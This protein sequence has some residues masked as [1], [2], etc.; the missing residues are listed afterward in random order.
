[1]VKT[2]VSEEIVRRDLD[3]MP[4]R[5]RSRLGILYVPVLRLSIIELEITRSCL[6]ERYYDALKVRPSLDW[7]DQSSFKGCPATRFR[8]P[9]V[10]SF[11]PCASQEYK[12][13]HI[14]NPPDMKHMRLID[15]VITTFRDNLEEVRRITT[16]LAII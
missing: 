5:N 15:R 10:C 7:R 11:R 8:L 12:L 3:F 1:M 16:E 2:T 4:V 13:G 14:T 6:I 9:L